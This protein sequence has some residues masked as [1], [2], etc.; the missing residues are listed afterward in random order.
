[1]VVAGCVG[2]A[3]DQPF[4]ELHVKCVVAVNL[5][6]IAVPHVLKQIGNFAIK[7]CVNVCVNTSI[8]FRKWETATVFIIRRR[9]YTVHITNGNQVC[10]GGDLI[11]QMETKHTNILHL[12]L[13]NLN[14]KTNPC[15][16]IQVYWL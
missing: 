9:R 8:H 12:L 2:I 14:Q 6:S 15:H 16:P 11:F 7:K 1:M 4:E 13:K 3:M 10:L 5:L